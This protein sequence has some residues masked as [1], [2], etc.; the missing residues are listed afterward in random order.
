MKKTAFFLAGTVFATL[1]ASDAAMAKKPFIS[2]KQAQDIALKYISGTIV[3]AE[4]EEENGRWQYAI[5]V[6]KDKKTLDI[7]IDAISGTILLVEID[8]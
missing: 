5:D 8:D 2:M 6:R 1:L 7:E 4:L 3:D